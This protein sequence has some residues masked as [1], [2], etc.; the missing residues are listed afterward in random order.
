MRASLIVAV[1]LAAGVVEFGL[2]AVA[3]VVER[4]LQTGVVSSRELQQPA[5]RNRQAAADHFGH[6]ALGD[7]ELFAEPAARILKA[8]ASP[9]VAV[10]IRPSVARHLGGPR[11]LGE[12]DR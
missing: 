6:G 4:A 7:A 1:T 10:Q 12:P 5:M 9:Q 3:A 8:R 2:D 11:G